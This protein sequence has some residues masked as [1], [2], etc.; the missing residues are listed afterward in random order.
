MNT[1]TLK[2]EIEAF[3]RMK[4]IL[5]EHHAGKYIIIKD[6]QLKGSFD[7]FDTAAREAIKLFGRGPYL[8]RKV[9]NDP[10]MPMPASVAYRPV[11]APH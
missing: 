8:I 9:S 10:V 4:S 1:Q 11:H 3:E 6:Q 2:P 7:T 5:L